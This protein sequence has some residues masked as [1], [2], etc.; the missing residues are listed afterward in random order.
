MGR[1]PTQRARA[2]LSVREVD[3]ADERVHHAAGLD[4][5][6][7]DTFYRREFPRLLDL[8]RALVGPTLAEDLAQEAMLVAY[9]RWDSICDIGSPTGYVRGICVHKAA[10]LVRRRVLERRVL[11]RLASRPAPVVDVLSDESERFWDAVR[12]LPRRQAQTVALR[13]A[14]ELPV[15]EI[16]EVLDCA[17]GTVKAQ[18]HRARQALASSLALGEVDQP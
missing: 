12:Q 2:V 9:R 16:A 11:G 17:E 4:A 7:F 15:A 6:P 13:Y 5:E 18:L 10:S 3:R 8:A 14:L 1:P